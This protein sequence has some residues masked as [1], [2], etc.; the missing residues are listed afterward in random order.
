MLLSAEKNENDAIVFRYL[1]KKK[2]NSFQTDCY[3]FESMNG[4]IVT[5]ETVIAKILNKNQ[6][7]YHRKVLT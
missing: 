2:L 3:R 6:W 4:S 5:D 7:C 1:K